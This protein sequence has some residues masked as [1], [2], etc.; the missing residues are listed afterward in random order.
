VPENPYHTIPYTTWPRFHS[1]PDRLAAVATLFGMQPAPVRSCR[2]LEI[3]CG[4]GG[5]LIPMAYYLP[6]SRF[7]GVDLADRAVEAGRSVVEGLELQNIELH[8]ADLRSIDESYGSFDYII[9]HGVYSWVPAEVRD[10]LLAVAAARLAPQG[11]AFISYNALPGRRVRE[12]LRDMMLHHTRGVADPQERVAQGRWLLEWLKQARTVPETWKALLDSEIDTLLECPPRSM[13]H[14]DMNPYNE[15]FYLHEVAA[16]AA[17]HGLQYLGDASNRMF[18][19]RGVLGWFEGSAVER[20]Q[21]L[22]YTY[23]RAFGET[24][25]CRADTALN[26]ELNPRVFERMSFSSPARRVE[27]QIVGYNGVRLAAGQPAV[28]PIAMALGESYPLPLTF[29]ELLPVAQGCESLVQTLA[30]M[31]RTTFV[32]YHVHDFACAR[33]P[34]ERPTATRLARYQAR[35]SNRVTNVRHAVVELDESGR[36]LLLLLDGTHTVDDLAHHLAQQP[37]LPTAVELARSI[38]ISLAWMAKMGV[39]EE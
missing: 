14:D 5:N 7:T 2:V 15:S 30:A 12:S 16:A 8:A 31:V 9:A 38:P 20:A 3:G 4:N 11:V 18:D 6:E 1:H 27:D 37:G 24:L 13:A 21:Y 28:E 39:L 33:T 19:I 32:Q 23:M 22:D 34:S 36:Q 35:D 17:S 10:A 25:L 29:Q 26:R